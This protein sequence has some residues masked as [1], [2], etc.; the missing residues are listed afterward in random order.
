MYNKIYVYY[1]KCKYF[2]IKIYDMYTY[3]RFKFILKIDGF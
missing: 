1:I 3:N 2:Y